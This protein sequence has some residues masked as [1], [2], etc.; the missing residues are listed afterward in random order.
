MKTDNINPLMGDII[1]AH[2]EPIKE[3]Q[4]PQMIRIK[5]SLKAEVQKSADK[6]NEGNFNREVRDLIQI[7]LKNRKRGRKK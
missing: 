3:L 7:G 2:S 5:P 4:E 6:H 1:K